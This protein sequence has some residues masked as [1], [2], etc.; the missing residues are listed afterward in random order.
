MDET[1][2]ANVFMK[3]PTSLQTW[4][5]VL[6]FLVAVVVVLIATWINLNYRSAQTSFKIVNIFVYPVKSCRG[7]AL[8]ECKTDALGFVNDRRFCIV[9]EMGIV[10][11]QRENRRLAT[12]QPSLSEGN[13][14]LS[15]SGLDALSIPLFGAWTS[16]E[17]VRIVNVRV[18]MNTV[19][20]GDA[21]A[22]WISAAL[23]GKKYRMCRLLEPRN[24][25]LDPKWRD[26]YS[27][28]E[29][30]T[31]SD[32]SQ[33][34]I[35]FTGSLRELNKR[36]KFSGTEPVPMDRFRPNIVLASSAG[37]AAE[38][39]VAELGFAGGALR[40][41]ANK[42]C[43]R[44]VVTTLDQ[45]TGAPTPRFQPLKALRGFRR[46]ADTRYGDS[47]LFGLNM[48]QRGDAPAVLRVGE[49]AAVAA[50]ARG[51]WPAADPVQ[52]AQVA[53]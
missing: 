14:I 11:T 6:S 43:H 27:E 32:G 21:A 15:C 50:W 48:S 30:A 29:C 52:S 53:A 26:A 20:C 45:A 16:L 7:V 3:M 41:R 5:F 8:D 36:M 13:L 51:P 46:G 25:K 35:A 44:C 9:D 24:N 22:K 10:V 33:F 37:F 4:A 34:L 12:I 38:D 39:T 28:A 1:V 31:F 49:A 40:L 19:D 47:P 2:T 18:P 17:Y 42:A 23:G